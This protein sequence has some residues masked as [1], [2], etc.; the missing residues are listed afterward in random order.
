MEVLIQDDMWWE[1]ELDDWGE[2]G[3]WEHG[4]VVLALVT[5]WAEGGVG[6]PVGKV[7]LWAGEEGL[8]LV[9]LKSGGW[10]VVVM[11]PVLVCVW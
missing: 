9:I 6:L 2:V 5:G 8:D 7:A 3:L 11:V 10:D 4:D 1:G